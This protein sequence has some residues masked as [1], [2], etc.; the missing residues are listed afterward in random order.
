MADVAAVLP[1]DLL[2]LEPPEDV[3]DVRA[4]LGLAVD[5]HRLPDTPKLRHL[6]LDNERGPQQSHL[7][8]NTVTF[9]RPSR[10]YSS[11]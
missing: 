7:A 10:V 6:P 9:R 2:V 11:H 8:S 3:G 1:L 5:H 4:A